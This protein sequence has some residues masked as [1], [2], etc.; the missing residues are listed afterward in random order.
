MSKVSMPSYWKETTLGE[1]GSISGGGTPSTKVPEYWDGEIFWLVP[2]VVTKNNGLFISQTERRIT[3]E[4]LANSST[5]LMPSGTVLMTSRATIGEVVINSVPMATNQGFIN[6]RCGDGIIFNEFLAY[7]IKLH[8]R[9]FEDRAHGVT[10]KEITKSNFKTIPIFLPPLPEQRAIARTLRAAHEAKEARQRE[11][12]LERERK[13]A[14]MQYLFTHG[15][16]GETRRQTEIGEIPESWHV[17]AVGDICKSIVP[18]RNKPKQFN[19]SIP[20]IT[21]PDI[22]DRIRVDTSLSGLGLTEEAIRAAGGRII[23]LGSVIMSCIGNFGI[24]AI[25]EREIVINQQLHAF[26]CPEFLDPYFLCHALMMQKSYMEG[27]ALHTVLAYLNKDKCNSVPIPLPSIDEQLQIR[28]ALSACDGKIEALEKE[29]ELLDELFKS[30]LEEL[31]T[32]QLSAVPLIQ[33]EGFE[34]TTTH[35]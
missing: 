10:F 22:R 23:P 6:I 25:A 33:S 24:A 26:I 19:G 12:T 20:W 28:G 5:R 29:A 17:V 15:T 35:T 21:I 3:P 31:M 4:G 32:G 11:L 34:T 27:I 1:I 18:G 2:S 7:W 16:R 13:A 9:I 14:L 8:K 30:I